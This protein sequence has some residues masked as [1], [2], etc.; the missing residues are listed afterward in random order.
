[1]KLFSDSVKKVSIPVEEIL[2]ETDISGDIVS[3]IENALSKAQIA[4]EESLNSML[5]NDNALKKNNRNTKSESRQQKVPSLK[6]SRGLKIQSQIPIAAS[7]LTHGKSNLVSP[8][9][10]SRRG[11]M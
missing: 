3:E 5:A 6:C 11:M 8:A 1:M 4:Y 10:R 7:K 2:E 9:N